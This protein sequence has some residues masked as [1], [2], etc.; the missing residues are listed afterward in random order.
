MKKSW[1]LVSEVVDGGVWCHGIYDKY[2]T[3]LGTAIEMIW[4]THE[5]YLGEGDFFNY[6]EAEPLDGDGGYY[7]LVQYKK[8]NWE[9]L[10]EEYYFILHIENEGERE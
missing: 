9:K 5:S 7:I 8:P 6:T 3:A 10:S 1:V 4:E 2:E